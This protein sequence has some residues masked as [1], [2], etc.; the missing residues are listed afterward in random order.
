M[1]ARPGAPEAVTTSVREGK[2]HRKLQNQKSHYRKGTLVILSVNNMNPFLY[3]Y[4]VTVKNTPV[5]ETAHLA[6]LAQFSPFIGG[7]IPSSGGG[8]GGTTDNKSIVANAPA[9][10]PISILK[11]GARANVGTCSTNAESALTVLA[12]LYTKMEDL[13]N[14]SGGATPLKTQFNTIDST[15]N[16]IG[17]KY[18]ETRQKLYDPYATCAD[19]CTAA[20][21]YKSF[22]E[23]PTHKLD[24]STLEDNLNTLH[25]YSEDLKN[26]ISQFST[27]YNDCTPLIQGFNYVDSLLTY[28]QKVEK[29][30]TDYDAE[31]TKRK[32][33]KRCT[34]DKMKE[35]IDKVFRHPEQTLRQEIPIGPF[36]DP[37]NVDITLIYD[38]N[39]DTGPLTTGDCGDTPTPPANNV[40][41]GTKPRATRTALTARTEA[42]SDAVDGSS[43]GSQAGDSQGDKT[44]QPGGGAASANNSTTQDAP[45]SDPKQKSKKLCFDCAPRFALSGGV[46]YTKLERQ[47]IK[48]VI[49]F[50]HDREGQLI[51]GQT[52]PTTIIG[53]TARSRQRLTPLLMLSTRLTPFKDNNLFFSLGITGK[54]TDAG[55]DIEYLIGPSLNFLD[56]KIFLTYGLY[57]GKVQRLGGDLFTGLKIPS[58]TSA[59][60]LPIVNEFHWK[61][62]W[63]L[64]YKIK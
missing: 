43:S 50:A 3:N 56:R 62:G 6:F 28:Q 57:G 8:G 49:G 25:A 4:T 11:T 51:S 58:D 26:G 31:I 33:K 45:P 47:E 48:P 21:D 14:G 23:A 59:D 63:A 38:S 18:N 39:P 52:D 1:D 54:K 7:V 20:Q 34:F 29:L 37:S 46:G 12:G 17:D 40:A 30:I 32:K 41:Q 53:V 15:Y 35:D 5:V 19:L 22:L 60:K 10:G 55:T 36:D 16:E 64:T 61:S 24:F 2:V 27:L 42:E 13:I 44:T 9:G